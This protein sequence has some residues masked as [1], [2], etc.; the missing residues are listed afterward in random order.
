M[1]AAFKLGQLS[2]PV[3]NSKQENAE[4][5]EA[6]RAEMQ[7]FLWIISLRKSQAAQE[8]EE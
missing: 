7:D 1:Q 8:R 4:E 3:A 6:G 2:S 5:T